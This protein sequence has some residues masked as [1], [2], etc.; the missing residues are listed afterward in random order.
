MEVK[1]RST[2]N[3]Y[4]FHN[5]VKGWDDFCKIISDKSELKTQYP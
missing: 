3:H 4:E 1:T 2:V 5:I